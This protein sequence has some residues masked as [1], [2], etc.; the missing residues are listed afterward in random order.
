[1]KK[2]KNNISAENISG[3]SMLSRVLPLLDPMN[4]NLFVF[5]YSERDQ[6]SDQSEETLPSDLQVAT[7]F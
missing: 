4:H 7:Q 3:A 5:G 1:M 6:H 2:W